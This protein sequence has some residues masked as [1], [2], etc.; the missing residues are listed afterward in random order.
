MTEPPWLP[1]APKTV[2]ILDIFKIDSACCLLFVLEN[3]EYCCE[4]DSYSELAGWWSL[5]A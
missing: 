4:V 5:Y 3:V 2:I 1:V